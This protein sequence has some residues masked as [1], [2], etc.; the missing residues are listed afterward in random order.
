M[1]I[2]EIPFLRDLEHTRTQ[3]RNDRVIADAAIDT[4]HALPS[5]T[6]RKKAYTAGDT[7]HARGCPFFPAVG[8][9]PGVMAG[10]DPMRDG[11]GI[12]HD[13]CT[14]RRCAR[15]RPGDDPRRLED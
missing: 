7:R 1:T 11:A 13:D 6:G 5:G 10:T 8:G 3:R 4:G 15:L 2:R 14:C 9:I 12:H